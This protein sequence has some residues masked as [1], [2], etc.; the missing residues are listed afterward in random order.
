MV[1]VYS[2]IGKEKYQKSIQILQGFAQKETGF[3]APFGSNLRSPL[4]IFR[5][6]YDFFILLLEEPLRTMKDFYT[7]YL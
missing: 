6:V 4:T 7:V 2:E 1:H 5:P 3:D